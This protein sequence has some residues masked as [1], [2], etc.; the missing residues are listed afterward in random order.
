MT[1]F[2]KLFAAVAALFLVFGGAAITTAAAQDKPQSL[3]IVHAPAKTSYQKGEPLVLD[4]LRVRAHYADGS[5][6]WVQK[7]LTESN[8]TGYNKNAP[9]SQTVTITYNGATATFDVMVTDAQSAAALIEMVTVIPAGKTVEIDG[10][11]KDGVFITDRNVTLS[12]YQIGKYEITYDQWYQVYKWATSPDRGS[13]V[14]KFKRPGQEGSM[15]KPG[16]LP[17]KLG[18][19]Q[20]V[21]NICDDD[22]GCNI[23]AWC[24]ALSEMTNHEPVY[25]TKD[26]K[27][28]RDC[29]AYHDD[30]TF[31]KQMNG[32]RLPTEAQWEFAARGGNPDGKEWAYKYAGSNNI[33]DVAW[34]SIQVSGGN[35]NPVG[36]LQPNSLGIYD[37]SGNVSELCLDTYASGFDSS[38]KTGSFRDPPTG[39]NIRHQRYIVARGGSVSQRWEG[40]FTV[41]YRER[42]DSVSP[43]FLGFR[44]VLPATDSGA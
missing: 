41:S 22:Y 44:V 10:Y 21:V 43:E 8:F 27:V 5:G 13:N 6:K 17:S 20:P 12:G 23:Y 33:D 26:R 37:M 24:N 28:F 25:Y 36:Q 3:E 1:K 32:Y 7:D 2:N 34:T 18:E 19:G 16:A 40:N 39:T 42:S 38:I 29:S 30:W 15:G 11:G 35:T 9:G 4:G 31:M 14:Y